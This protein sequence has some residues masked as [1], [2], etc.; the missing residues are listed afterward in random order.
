MIWCILPENIWIFGNI[1]S[2]WSVVGWKYCHI[3][4]SLYELSPHWIF[5]AASPNFMG[6]IDT[7]WSFIFTMPTYWYNLSRKGMICTV[8]ILLLRI[9]GTNTSSIKVDSMWLAQFRYFF[10]AVFKLFHNAITHATYLLLL[11]IA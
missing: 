7:L 5:L 10:H 6:V 4:E 3:C 1:V 9:L 11:I 2:Q 8:S